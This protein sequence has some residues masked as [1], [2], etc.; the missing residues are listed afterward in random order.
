MSNFRWLFQQVTRFWVKS[1]SKGVLG[2]CS[3]S[4][5]LYFGRIRLSSRRERGAAPVSGG[6][7]SMS[8]ESCID[9]PAVC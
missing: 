4:Q 5:N 8:N 3:G 1:P 9:A 7:S 2:S 6:K